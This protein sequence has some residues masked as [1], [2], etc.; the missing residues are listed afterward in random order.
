MEPNQVPPRGNAAR[1]FWAQ[2]KEWLVTEGD[3]LG[4]LARIVGTG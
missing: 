3:K 1:R 4:V 2:Q